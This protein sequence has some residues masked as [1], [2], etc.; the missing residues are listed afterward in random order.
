MLEP[1]MN[2][3]RKLS[4]LPAGE[5][6]TLVVSV[7]RLVTARILLSMLGVM[8]TRRLFD[9][10]QATSRVDRA[11]AEKLALAVERAA[12]NLMLRTNCLDRA[13]AVW[14]SLKAQ[15][16][17]AVLRIG[18]RKDGEETLAAHAWVEHDGA[19]LFDETAAGFQPF[20]APLMVSGKR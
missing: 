8:R 15:G 11:A 12:R 4:T 13:V 14:W 5:R 3:W 18:V 2:R 17:E 10:G 20:D 9:G 7:L 16:L 6:Y 19:V 1:L